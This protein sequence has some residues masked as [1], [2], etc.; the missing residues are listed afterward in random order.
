MNLKYLVTLAAFLA[1]T[2][3]YAADFSFSCQDSATAPTLTV[4]GASQS[5]AH[6]GGVK[7]IFIGAMQVRDESKIAISTGA[8]QIDANYDVIEMADASDQNEVS[9]MLP[10]G[11]GQVND[12]G[13]N[14][15]LSNF[16]A[17][18]TLIKL[19]GDASQASVGL[20]NDVELTCQAE[21]AQADRA[22]SFFGSLGSAWVNFIAGVSWPQFSN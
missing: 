16:T 11:V 10:F 3:A 17:N 12:L 1:V 6:F 4:L 5:H 8:N 15:S 14:V 13:S 9:V 20:M 18:A 19:D 7:Y 2:G 22:N 21:I